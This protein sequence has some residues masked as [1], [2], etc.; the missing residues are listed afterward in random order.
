M[1]CVQFRE[2]AA[3]AAGG[4]AVAA[5]TGIQD[6]HLTGFVARPAHPRDALP[7]HPRPVALEGGEYHAHP[8]ADEGRVGPDRELGG[9][10]GVPG[11]EHEVAGGLVEVGVLGGA[12]RDGVRRLREDVAG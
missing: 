3:Q 1:L 8:F 10:A 11:A 4:Q 7:V 6:M 12:C 9:V 2:C 5:E